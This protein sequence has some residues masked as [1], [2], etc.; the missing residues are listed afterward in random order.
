MQWNEFICGMSDDQR[1][2]LMHLLE[3]GR[4]YAGFTTG[5][6]GSADVE[7]VIA[8]LDQA[9]DALA[10]ARLL[11]G[12]PV[13]PRPWKDAAYRAYRTSHPATTINLRPRELE[14]VLAAARELHARGDTAERRSA[15]AVERKAAVAAGRMLKRPRL[16]ALLG[17]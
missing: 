3:E 14:K 1:A 5:R 13:E 11:L 10:A 7:Q 15:P 9:L 2:R 8:A 17:G 6:I 4:Q 16:A 12:A